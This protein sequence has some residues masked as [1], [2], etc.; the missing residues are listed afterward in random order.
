MELCHLAFGQPSDRGRLK[1]EEV[2]TYVTDKQLK[3]IQIKSSTH[4]SDVHAA[5]LLKQHTNYMYLNKQ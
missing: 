1:E 2:H 5:Q 3:A 4:H